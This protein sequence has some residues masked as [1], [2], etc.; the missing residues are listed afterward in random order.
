MRK[1][2]FMPVIRWSQMLSVLIGAQFLVGPALAGTVT[3]SIPEPSTMSLV[4]LGAVGIA[5]AA[6]KRR[7]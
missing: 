4:A 1:Q 5:V 3:A 2:K 7:K 6:R